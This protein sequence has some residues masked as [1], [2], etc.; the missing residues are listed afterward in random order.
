MFQNRTKKTNNRVH[1]VPV[2]NRNH[3]HRKTIRNPV[4]PAKRKMETKRN[5]MRWKQ[6]KR[7]QTVR[8]NW[9]RPASFCWRT[10][11]FS[12]RSPTSDDDTDIHLP[13]NSVEIQQQQQQQHPFTSSKNLLFLLTTASKKKNI[14]FWVSKYRNKEGPKTFRDTVATFEEKK[15]IRFPHAHNWMTK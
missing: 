11:W 2:E 13:R 5:E 12:D 3:R 9:M 14:S 10:A 4:E 7:K 15:T 6:K 8:C 1:D